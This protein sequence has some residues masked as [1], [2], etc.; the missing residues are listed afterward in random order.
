VSWLYNPKDDYKGQIFWDKAEYAQKLADGW[1][2]APFPVDKAEEKE[3]II[4]VFDQA[5]VVE[6]KPRKKPG[7]PKGWKKGK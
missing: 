6:V 7:P 3:K 2:T 4:Q 5:A 1:E